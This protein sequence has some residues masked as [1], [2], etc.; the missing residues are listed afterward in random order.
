MYTC[1]VGDIFTMIAEPGNYEGVSY[2]LLRCTV[3]R[4]KLYDPEESDEIL[5]PIGI[6]HTCVHT[7]IYEFLY[8]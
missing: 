8:I 5:F 6:I 7:Y 3:E 4:T 1:Y 2:Y